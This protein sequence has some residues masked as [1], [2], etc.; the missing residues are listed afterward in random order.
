MTPDEERAIAAELEAEAD[1]LRR[2]EQPPVQPARDRPVDWGQPP[3]ILS[4]TARSEALAFAEGV[5]AAMLGRLALGT[6]IDRLAAAIAA[7]RAEEYRFGEASYV[8]AE[9]VQQ[10][11]SNVTDEVWDRA[12]G[13][14]TDLLDSAGIPY[15]ET[16]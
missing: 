2:G 16:D 8:T 6:R 3:A 4:E 12:Y 9:R 1:R 7:Y 11:E 10:L 14:A 15:C 5:H 13:L